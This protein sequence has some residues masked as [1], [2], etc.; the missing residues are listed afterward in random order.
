[1]QTEELGLDLI[2]KLK[3]LA[4]KPSTNKRSNTHLKKCQIKETS[5]SVRH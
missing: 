1:M 4:T 3:L 2:Q 5:G